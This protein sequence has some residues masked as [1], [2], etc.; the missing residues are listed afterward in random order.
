MELFALNA[1]LY[2]EFNADKSIK[3]ARI[4]F[5][6]GDLSI[7]LEKNEETTLISFMGIEISSDQTT[8]LKEK[9][10]EIFNQLTL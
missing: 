9:G 8:P 1:Q 10:E 7:L 6:Q 3:V 5:T 2:F 4:A